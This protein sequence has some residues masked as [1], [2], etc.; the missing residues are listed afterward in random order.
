MFRVA[1]FE[2][3]WSWKAGACEIDDIVSS[4]HEASTT[5]RGKKL[6]VLFAE[7]DEGLHKELEKLNHGHPL[8]D[9][10][11]FLPK[12]AMYGSPAL[13]AARESMERGEGGD[14]DEPFMPSFPTD[15]HI[16]SC[17]V[18]L[19]KLCAGRA[20]KIILFGVLAWMFLQ[21]F[22]FTDWLMSAGS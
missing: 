20:A 15:P 14:H 8:D 2:S 5:H 18:R 9:V 16:V 22:G 21:S 10:R 11:G 12:A 7:T 4:V 6:L 13:D 17:W 3:E 19:S 1:V